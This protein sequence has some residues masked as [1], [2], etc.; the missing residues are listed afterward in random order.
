MAVDAEGSAAADTVPFNFSRAGMVA[1]DQM[2]TLRTLD[3]QFA[4]NLTHTL[5][6]WLRT[7]ITVTPQAPEQ[8]VYSQFAESTASG[9]HILPVSVEPFQA[10]AVLASDLALAPAMID[11]LLGGTGRSSSLDRELTEIEDAVLRSVLDIVLREWTLVWQPFGME[12]AVRPHEP[13]AHGQRPM[14]LQE[15]TYCSRFQVVLAET[16]GD[17]AFCMPSAALASALRAF[18]YRR[19]RQR[20]RGPED[21]MRMTQRLGASRLVAQLHFPVMQL[22]AEELQAMT[23]GTLLS[24]PLSCGA[25]AELRVSGMPLFRA[26]PVRAGEHRAA[27]IVHAL[28]E[29]VSAGAPPATGTTA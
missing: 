15:R 22:R 28:Q 24:L 3:E 19:E 11:L 26:K 25:E 4:R 13:G 14:P 18:A 20:H 8:G 5:S 1:P 23:P 7:T 16:T 29:P 2:R 17:L 10:R 21:R 6:A 12:F 9:R 27:Q